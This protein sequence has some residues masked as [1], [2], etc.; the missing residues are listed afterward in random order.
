MRAIVVENFGDVNELKLKEASVPEPKS[1]Q[2]LIEQYATSV[3]PSDLKKRKGLW[4]GKLP[5]IPGGDAAGV[6]RKVGEKVTKF[7]PGDRVMAN[8]AAT[9]AEYVVAR[10]SVVGHIPETI[11]FT[12]AAGL[13]LAGQTAY[14]AVVKV[15]RVKKGE[16]ILIHA[17]AG[18]VGTLAIQMAKNIGA[19]VITTASGENEMFL[20]SMGVDQVINYQ[21]TSFEKEVGEIDFVLDTIGGETQKKSLQVLRKGGRLVTLAEAPQDDWLKTAQVE[22]EAISMKPSEEGMAYLEKNLSSFNLRTF[23]QEIYPFTELGVQQAHKISEQGHVRG[24]LIVEIK[25][26]INKA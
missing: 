13:P 17:G 1:H 2:V 14:Q 26:E 24:K 10:E 7:K 8:A 3:N 15:G 21:K 9:Y 11:P 23:V 20:Y 5:F 25:Q 6:V 12:E 16:K 18:G 22:G 19:E 4:K